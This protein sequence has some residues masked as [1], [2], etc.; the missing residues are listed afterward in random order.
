MSNKLDKSY[1]AFRFVFNDGSEPKE[2]PIHKYI[3][4]STAVDKFGLEFAEM[5]DGK[6]RLV[7]NEKM[8]PDFTKVDRIE[9]VRG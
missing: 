9:V 8:I 5:K 3:T 7:V 4:I 6:C 2:F 1:R